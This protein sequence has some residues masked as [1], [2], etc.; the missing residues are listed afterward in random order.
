MESQLELLEGTIRGSGTR[1]RVSASAEVVSTSAAASYVSSAAAAFVST[2]ENRA[3]A[4]ATVAASTA[5]LQSIMTQLEDLMQRK[6]E[7]LIALSLPVLPAAPLHGPLPP[8]SGLSQSLI[9]QPTMQGNASRNG[10][11]SHSSKEDAQVGVDDDRIGGTGYVPSSLS[12]AAIMLEEVSNLRFTVLEL[13]DATWKERF[14]QVLEK[15]RLELVNA[16]R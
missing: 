2:A 11:M 5:L 9:D 3:A 13:A 15:A 14:L 1:G 12:P 10:S 6:E 7:L 4:A 16:T 8:P